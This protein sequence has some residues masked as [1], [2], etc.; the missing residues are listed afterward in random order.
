M[1]NFLPDW[2][3]R[4]PRPVAQVVLIYL[5]NHLPWVATIGF[6]VPIISSVPGWPDQTWTDF[7]ARHFP[8]SQQHFLAADKGVAELDGCFPVPC[9][10]ASNPSW[11]SPLGAR[12]ATS[13]A[14]FLKVFDPFTL[15]YLFLYIC[16]LPVKFGGKMALIA[17]FFSWQTK[18]LVICVQ[19][20][21]GTE[22][23]LE[24]L[25]Y[26]HLVMSSNPWSLHVQSTILAPLIFEPGGSIGWDPGNGNPGHVVTRDLGV[27]QKRGAYTFKHHS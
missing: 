6:P 24:Y 12:Q 27:P 19:G 23:M 5:S 3:G 18:G 21:R 22:W 1:I 15:L 17:Y 8:W 2:L 20:G 9:V 14:T 26:K 7:W 4:I 11:V 16:L 25:P 10:K 13:C